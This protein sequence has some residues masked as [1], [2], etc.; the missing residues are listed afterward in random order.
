MS[1]EYHI[2]YIQK[3]KSDAFSF[4]AHHHK[5]RSGG[6]VALEE[7]TR[8][9]FERFPYVCPEPVLVKRCALYTNGIAKSGVSL[10]GAEGLAARSICHSAAAF[11]A[12]HNSFRKL[13]S[14][15]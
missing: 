12:G 10:P 7:E 2:A 14:P 15:V 13:S 9:F 8:V 5:Y 4:S 3:Q 1:E 6:A 11:A